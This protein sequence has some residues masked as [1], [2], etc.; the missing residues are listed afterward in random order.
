MSATDSADHASMVDQA[1]R[2]MVNPQEC[3]RFDK[4]SKAHNNKTLDFSGFQIETFNQK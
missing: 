1:S 3:K 2:I 4:S